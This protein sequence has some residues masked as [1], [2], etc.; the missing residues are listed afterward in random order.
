MSGRGS[1]G[2]GVEVADATSS[3][4]R[5]GGVAFVPRSRTKD[6]LQQAEVIMAREAVIEQPGEGP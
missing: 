6:V 4:R 5:I 3:S 1:R 2:G